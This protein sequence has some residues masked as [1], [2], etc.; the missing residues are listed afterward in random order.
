MNTIPIG[1]VKSIVKPSI[2]AVLATAGVKEVII[3]V[4]QRSV[5]DDEVVVALGLNAVRV[6]V[7]GVVNN[8]V[9]LGAVTAEEDASGIVAC[10][11]IAKIIT[12]GLDLKSTS[13]ASDCGV[14]MQNSPRR[15]ADSE[16]YAITLS[17]NV[18]YLH[19]SL[20]SNMNIDSDVK[21]ADGARPGDR[22]YVLG[23]GIDTGQATASGDVVTVQIQGHIGVD[24]DPNWGA[25]R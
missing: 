22:D 23:I 6:I 17:L 11:V 25:I 21:G 14:P 20:I 7:R 19:R 1:R 13:A 10:R 4:V 18:R 15:S 16:S 2:V 5:G 12:D 24:L 8:K 9:V 3:L